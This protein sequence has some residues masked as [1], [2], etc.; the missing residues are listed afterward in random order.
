MVLEQNEKDDN[1]TIQPE[2]CN[3]NTDKTNGTTKSLN[4]EPGIPELMAF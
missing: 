2:I 1:I 3:I 4:D